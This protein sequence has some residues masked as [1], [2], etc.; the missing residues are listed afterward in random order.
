MDVFIVF[1]NHP[2]FLSYNNERKKRFYS[3]VIELHVCMLTYGG[4]ILWICS[5][6]GTPLL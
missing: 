4:G 2:I 6:L 1:Q 3:H 5:S